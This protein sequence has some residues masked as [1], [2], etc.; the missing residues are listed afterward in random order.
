MPFDHR[1]LNRFSTPP[2][3]IITQLALC[4]DV[5]GNI[6]TLSSLIIVISALHLLFSKSNNSAYMRSRRIGSLIALPGDNISFTGSDRGET[7]IEGSPE[8]EKLTAAEKDFQDYYTAVLIADTREELARA[9]LDYYRKSVS[10]VISNPKS[11]ASAA[12]LMK[13]LPDGLPLFRQSTDAMIFRSV[14]DSLKTVWPD[15]AVVKALDKEA[16]RRQSE[17]ELY[18]RLENAQEV[19]FPDI[20]LPG[21]DGKN[22]KLSEVESKVTMLYFWASSAEQN[23]FNIDALL[24]I[25]EEFAPKGLE[26]FAVSLDVDKT[27]W[28]GVVRGQKLPWLNVC[29]TRGAASPFIGLYGL[30]SLPTIWFI[31]DG[32]IDTNASVS[33]AESIRTYLNS[34]LK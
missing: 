7:Y 30:N 16:S 25:Y 1:V 15:A 5:S 29:D 2:V 24:P 26:I 32:T 13:E 33:D 23:M 8:S 34:K 9:Y 6:S 20:E 12:V 28:A 11:L 3:A 22:L 19:P 4:N 14:T 18:A 31:T 21:M 10:F 27:R 17:M